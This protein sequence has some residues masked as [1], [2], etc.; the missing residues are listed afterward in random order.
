[1]KK[2]LIIFGLILSLKIQAQ[3]D[4]KYQI[5]EEDYN[6]QNVEM[7]DTMRANG[8]IYVV[9]AVMLIIFAG[10]TFYLYRME[11]KVSALEKEIKGGK[12]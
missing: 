7:A 11:R 2:L 1:M 9:V 12:Q 4:E 3:N 8:K 5:T 10:L 6:N